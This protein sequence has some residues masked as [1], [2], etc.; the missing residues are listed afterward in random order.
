MFQRQLFRNAVENAFR[1]R[2][3]FGKRA[4][5]AVILAG[6]TQDPAVV[7]EIDVPAL[8]VSAA[9]AINRGVERHPV[10]GR[11]LA[12]RVSD[13]GNNA[14]GLMPHNNGWPTSA[15]AAVHAVDIA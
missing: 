8:T 14:R 12:H 11:P 6:D 13:T 9:S 3:K 1:H 2:H 7:A 10:T 4:V 5:L 15:R